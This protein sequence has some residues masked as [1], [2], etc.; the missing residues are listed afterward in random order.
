[1]AKVII[2]SGSVGSGKTTVAKLLTRMLKARLVDVKMIIE[3]RKEVVA[4]YDAKRKTKEVDI[5]KLN[6]IILRIIKSAKETL[7]IDSHMSHYL[8]KNAVDLCIICKCDLKE[9]K[10]RLQKRKYHAGKVREN[11]DAEIFDVCLVEAT[12]RGHKIIIII[13]TGQDVKKQVKKIVR[14]LK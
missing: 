7:V 13:D 3:Q 4:G 2:V 10:K 12:E 9:L 11:L 5:K 8:P 1:M 14:L 6:K